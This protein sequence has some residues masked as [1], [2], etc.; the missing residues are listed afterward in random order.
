MIKALFFLPL[1]AVLSLLF[2]SGVDSAADTQSG[3]SVPGLKPKALTLLSP[4]WTGPFQQGQSMLIRWSSKN[5]GPREQ[6]T[7]ALQRDSDSSYCNALAERTINDGVEEVA[8]PACEPGTDAPG[9]G[10]YRFV[11][12]L[13]DEPS[14]RD[15][16]RVPFGGACRGFCERFRQGLSPDRWCVY[17]KRWGRGNNGAVP[18]NVAVE[19]DVVD[20]KRQRVIALYGHG[21]RYSGPVKGVTAVRESEGIRHV[22]DAAGTRV[23]ACIATKDYFASGAYEATMKIAETPSPCGACIGAWLFHYEEHR[24]AEGDLTGLLLNALDPLYQPQYRNSASSGS[25]YSSV[26]SEIDAPEMGHARNGDFFKR[27][28]FNTFLTANDLEKGATFH[29]IQLLSSGRSVA[30]GLYHRYRWEWRTEL[31]EITEL[32]PD[33]LI[34]YGSYHYIHDASSPF[35]GMAA[36]KIH[37]KCYVCRGRDVTFYVD[38]RKIGISTTNV[39]AVSARM[40]IG[41]WFPVWA[42][43]ADWEQIKVTVAEVSVTPWNM[44]GDVLN[45]PETWPG[46]GLVPPPERLWK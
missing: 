9:S 13:S 10:D 16:S 46:K 7:I 12:F 44:A 34:D 8:M 18:D 4:E 17:L 45:Q 41:V 25:F 30:D 27:G 33:R 36:V 11:V 2:F 35:Q 32:P 42:G 22:Q 5:V 39:S 15:L 19:E 6:I 40:I 29:S 3:E 26:N 38:G 23:G 21:D 14:V 24:S 28:A 20:G 43:P 1:V 37:S 31:K